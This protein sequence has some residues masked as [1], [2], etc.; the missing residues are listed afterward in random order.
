MKLLTVTIPAY[1]SQDYLAACVESILPGGDRLE[2]IIIDDG[3]KDATGAIA[4][5]YAE[6]YPSIVRVIHQENG[7]HGE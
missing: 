6:K 1:N 2:I 4:D 7:G 5:S 3:S